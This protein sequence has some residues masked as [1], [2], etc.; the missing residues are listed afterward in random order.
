MNDVSVFR[1]RLARAGLKILFWIAKNISPTPNR[2]D[3]I[4][5][6]GCCGKL[7]AQFANENV[8]DFEFWLV[9]API[10]VVEEHFLRQCCALAQ[11]EQF[12]HAVFFAGEVQALAAD[13]DRFGVQVDRKLASLNS[14]LCVAFRTIA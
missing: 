12:E 7:L 13:F 4:V 5:A 14:G 1:R 10:E 6:G 3:I 11:A 9:H 8:D 2:F